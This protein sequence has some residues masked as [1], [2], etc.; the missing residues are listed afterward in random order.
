MPHDVIVPE[1]IYRTPNYAHAVRAGNTLYI[2]GQVARDEAGNLVGRGDPGAQARQ[3]YANLGA[4]LRAAGATPRHVVKITTYLTDATHGAAV[5]AARFEFFGDY[6][7][8]HTGLFV[9]LG[10]GVLVEIDAIAV[11]D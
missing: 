7:P 1:G 5:T 10:E 8:P 3:A 4:I 2:A 9:G 6:R 11:L